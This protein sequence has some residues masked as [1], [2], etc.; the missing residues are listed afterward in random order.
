[1]NF[2]TR[3]IASFKKVIEYIVDAR[4]YNITISILRIKDA[5]Y[6]YVMNYLKTVKM[7]NIKRR[8]IIWHNKH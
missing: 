5:L 7:F 3:D 1:M 6:Q 8:E 2:D 4:L